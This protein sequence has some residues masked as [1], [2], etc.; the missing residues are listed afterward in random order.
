MD[1]PDF[2]IVPSSSLNPKAP[3]FQPSNQPPMS[4]QINT[5]LKNLLERQKKRNTKTSNL[6]K[7]VTEIKGLITSIEAQI[8]LLISSGGNYEDIMKQL[9]PII[10]DL[11]VN[12]NLADNDVEELE[13]SLTEIA[14]R[15]RDTHTGLETQTKKPSNPPPPPASSFSGG[16]K[17]SKTNSRKYMVKKFRSTRISSRRM[18]KKKRKTLRRSKR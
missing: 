16:Y 1:G 15:L 11:N 18:N 3:N 17:H 13:K 8:K 2:P 14:K 12:A 9:Q 10:D 5:S 6:K 7:L 4:N